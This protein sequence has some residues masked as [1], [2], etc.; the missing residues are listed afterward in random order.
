MLMLQADAL[1]GSMYLPTDRSIYTAN[2]LAIFL[3]TFPDTY[4]GKLA[5][6]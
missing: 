4:G 2:F 3:S 1:Y 5:T 6:V